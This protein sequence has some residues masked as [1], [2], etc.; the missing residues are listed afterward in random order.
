MSGGLLRRGEAGYWKEFTATPIC[1]TTL[2]NDSAT[3][4]CNTTLQHDSATRLCNTTLQHD[5]ATRLCNTM[6]ARGI[7]VRWPARLT[8]GG[9]GD[10]VQKRHTVKLSTSGPQRC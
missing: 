4:L 9:A 6:A 7:L 5:S 3:R 8:G 2:Q 1:K 10:C